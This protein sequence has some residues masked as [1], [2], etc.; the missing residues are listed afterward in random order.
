[1]DRSVNARVLVAVLSVLSA[2]SSSASA[3]ILSFGAVTEFSGGTPPAV[4]PNPP[5]LTVQFDDHG[6]TGAV[7]LTI[8]A[9]NLTGSEFVSR[10]YL[11]IDPVLESLLTATDFSLPT[12]TGSFGDV[13]ITVDANNKK[14]DGDGK[15]DILLSFPTANSGA[16]RFGAGDAVSYTIS[17]ISSLTANSFNFKSVGSSKAYPMAA[18]I[19]GDGDNGAD[20]WVTVVPE[21]CSMTLLAIGVGMLVVSSRLRRR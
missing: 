13:S 14:A 18:H 11:N 9:T 2:F 21:P 8:T 10:L 7:D 3:T 4:T 16:G 20:G 19:Q 12:K 17:S 6:S 1:M 15:Y 5:W